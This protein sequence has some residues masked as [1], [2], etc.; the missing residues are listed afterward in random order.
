[1]DRIPESSGLISRSSRYSV[2]ETMDRL[3]VLVKTHGMKIFARIDQKAEAEAV[4]LS[5][6]PT[7]LLFFGDPRTGTPLMNAHP[8]LAIDLP[9]KVMAWQDGEGRVWLSYVDP[10]VLQQRHGLKEM[11]FKALAGLIDQALVG[12]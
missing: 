12:A 4:G 11:P 8:S 6:T 1:M 9:L 2:S 3:E 5:M 7:Q 10:A